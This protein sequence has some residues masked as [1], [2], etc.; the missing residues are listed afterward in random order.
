MPTVHCSY[1]IVFFF[2]IKYI[3]SNLSALTIWKLWWLSQELW[4]PLR[5]LT[6]FREWTIKKSLFN[7]KKENYIAILIVL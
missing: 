7:R 1:S 3:D 2:A 4:D 6:H 5:I